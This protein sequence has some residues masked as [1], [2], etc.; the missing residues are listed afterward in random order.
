MG[1]L[2]AGTAGGGT[3]AGVTGEISNVQAARIAA[4]L[5]ANTAT[6]AD[7]LTTA[8]AVSALSRITAKVIGADI[9]G[10]GAFDFTDAGAAGFNLGDGDTAIDGLV[11][12]LTAGYQ[13]ATITPV[14]LQLILV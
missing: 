3:T 5:A 9:D 13:T 1:G 7:A 4:I 8:N 2:F 14:P 6:E 10:D 12:A 11:I